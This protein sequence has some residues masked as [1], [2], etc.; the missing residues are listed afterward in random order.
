MDLG[1]VLSTNYLNYRSMASFYQRI[2]KMEWI[3]LTEWYDVDFINFIYIIWV[4]FEW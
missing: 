2:S 1:V 4:C 3:M